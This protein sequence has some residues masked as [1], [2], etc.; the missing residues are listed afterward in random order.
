MTNFDQVLNIDHLG[1][2][3]Y[4][5]ETLDAIYGGEVLS[6]WMAETDFACPPNIKKALQ[7]VVAKDSYTYQYK[8]PALRK[9][10]SDWYLHRHALTIDPDHLLFATGVMT[11]ISAAIHACSSEG[12]GII[13]QPPVYQEFKSTINQLNR[14]VVKNPLIE[15]SGVYRMDFDDLERQAQDPKNKILLICNPHN[16]IGR[17]WTKE[18]LQ[19]VVAICKKTETLLLSDEIHSDIILD[20]HTFIGATKFQD[21]SKIIM[22]GSPGKTFGIPGIAEAFIYTKD[23][24]LHQIMKEQITRF[25]LLKSNSFTNAATEA[26]YRKDGPWL[27]EM[28]QYVSD[29]IAFIDSFLRENVPNVRFNPPQGTYQI[30]LDFRQLGLDVHELRD[31]LKDAGIGLNAGYAYGRE[32]A[33]FARMNVAC[34]REVIAEAMNRLRLAFIK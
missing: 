3:K 14:E 11:G 7:N 21:Y 15:K 28:L 23:K 30:W 34:P 10:I 6:F 18:E 29:N 32:G 16:P 9:S 5:P 4:N 22:F 24:E 8:T 26:G 2:S 31:F 25:H 33:G 12:D 27:D 17:V 19:Q 1:E 20:E 13:I